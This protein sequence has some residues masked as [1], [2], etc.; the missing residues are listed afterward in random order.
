M[1]DPRT[2]FTEETGLKI[3]IKVSRY[4][5]ELKNFLNV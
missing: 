1:N 3:T 5:A 4:I 2:A